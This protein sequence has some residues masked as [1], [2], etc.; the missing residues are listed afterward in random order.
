[1]KKTVRKNKP[2]AR[3]QLQHT[4]CTTSCTTRCNTSCT[5]SRNFPDR[6]ALRNDHTRTCTPH[7]RHE[8]NHHKK[9]HEERRPS[10]RVND[11]LLHRT[12]RRNHQHFFPTSRTGRP[13]KRLDTL[14]HIHAR[15]SVADDFLPRGGPRSRRPHRRPHRRHHA[16]HRITKHPARTTK[17]PA[18]KR[19]RYWSR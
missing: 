8:K 5:T 9:H 11:R 10:P 7:E 1:M 13:N 19:H 4:R 12:G 17:A 16:V 3:R 15:P 14:R 18:I 2:T 6:P